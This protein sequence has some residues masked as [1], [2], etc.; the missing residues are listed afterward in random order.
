MLQLGIWVWSLLTL[1][2]VLYLNASGTVVNPLQPGLNLALL[3]GALHSLYFWVLAQSYSIGDVSVVYPVARGSAVAFTAVLDVLLLAPLLGHPPI[4]RLGWLGI[5]GVVLGVLLVGIKLTPHVLAWRGGSLVVEVPEAKEK[6][7]ADASKVLPWALLMGAL[8][9]AY[10]AVDVVGLRH[11]DTFSFLWVNYLSSVLFPLPLLLGSQ[12]EE[13]RQAWKDLRSSI[14]LIGI[15][16]PGTHLVVLWALSGGQTS[17][18]I[19]IREISIVAAVGLGVVFLG[20]P[21]TPQKL[22]GLVVLISS[23]VVIKMA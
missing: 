8:I 19:A 1:P 20:E 3:S 14:L 13:A 11:W 9:A 12:R 6:E 5:G 2:L 7:E 23:I 18:I 4:S 17:Y 10:T 21:L 16:S 15:A 22:L